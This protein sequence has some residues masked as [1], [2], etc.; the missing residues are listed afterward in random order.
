MTSR[1]PQ[2]L[3]TFDNPPVVEVALGVEFATLD[4][5]TVLH[6]GLFWGKIRTEFPKHQLNPASN[7]S[8]QSLVDGLDLPIR[9][10]F[11]T[12]S[13]EILIQLQKNRFI[14]N[15]RKY[16]SDKIVYPHFKNLIP[17]FKKY[18]SLFTSFLNEIDLDLNVQLCDITYVNHIDRGDGWDSIDELHNVF[19]SLS[20]FQ[21]NSLKALSLRTVASIPD[22][23]QSMIMNID[24][25][26]RQSDDQEIIVFSITSR[27]ITQSYSAQELLDIFS[28]GQQNIVAKFESFTS[29]GMHQFWGKR[30]RSIEDD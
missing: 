9:F 21:E 25:A 6:A 11:L 4:A 19:P 20:G 5:L 7:I 1:D 13:E 28:E 17:L 27:A 15:W 24:H 8:G 3:P 16:A 2:T 23:E 29:S 30:E 22:S 14:F 18:W 12:E 10:W 26:T